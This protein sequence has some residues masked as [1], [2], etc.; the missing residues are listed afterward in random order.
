MQHRNNNGKV[1]WNC[2]CD[3][4]KRTIVVS[5]SLVSNNTKSCGCDKNKIKHGQRKHP[6]YNT[7]FSMID[8]CYNPNSQAYRNYGKRGITVCD[9][10]MDI[11]NFIQDM[12]TRPDNLTLERID[13][14]GPYGKKNC[15]WAT[16]REQ[17][18]NKRN[19]I[20]VHLRGKE[21]S[22]SDLS[23]ICKVNKYTLY[24]RIF[25]QRLSP[26]VA[27]IKPLRSIHRGKNN[28]GGLSFV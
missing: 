2:L 4:G 13:N 14:D 9:S 18:N 19:T 25:V 1:L 15:K 16:R 5:G 22:I 28:I 20:I 21:I 24:H 12:G 17:N 10:W 8:R 23:K 6:N 7:W 26:E 11:N 27:I 3:C